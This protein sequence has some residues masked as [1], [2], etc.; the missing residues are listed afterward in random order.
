[1]PKRIGIISQRFAQ[2]LFLG[3]RRGD[4]PSFELIEE[5]SAQLAIKLREKNLDGAFLSPIDYAKDYSMYRIVPE[6]GAVSE[7]ESGTILLFFRENIARINTLAI[8]PGDTSEIVL[9]SIIFQEK[10][11]TKLKIIPTTESLEDALKKADA[12]LAVGDE[13]LRLQDKPNKMDLVDEWKDITEL[14][15]VHGTWVS[16][17]G[18]LTKDEI[19]ILISSSKQVDETVTEVVPQFRYNLDDIAVKA[20]GEFFR[21]AYYHGILKDIP[22]VKFFLYKS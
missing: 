5:S 18:S 9:A 2:P 11:D 22:D 19:E 1:V 8:N 17:E 10:Y 21:M 7:G 4:N 6:V 12:F 3:L 16:P 13:A 14:P 15:Y 20:L